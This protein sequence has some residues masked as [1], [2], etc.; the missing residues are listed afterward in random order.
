MKQSRKSQ[1]S[2]QN[3][4]V[5]S[6]RYFVGLVLAGLMPSVGLAYSGGIGTTTEPYVI[7]L[8]EDL[9]QLSLTPKDYDK[10]F[11]MTDDIDQHDNFEDMDNEIEEPVKGTNQ[12]TIKVRNEVFLG[13]L[14]KSQASSIRRNSTLFALCPRSS[15]SI[16]SSRLINWVSI[17][18]P[19][20][21][22]KN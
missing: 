18:T 17:V 11:L 22:K 6:L 8:S 2:H 21:I 1:R 19:F 10:H 7:S 14:I 12:V 3:T 5:S 16:L 4:V 13:V 15:F 20:F 9:V